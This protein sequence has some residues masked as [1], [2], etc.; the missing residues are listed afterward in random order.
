MRRETQPETTR[1]IMTST[2]ETDLPPTPHSLCL[3][4]QLQLD[5]LRAREAR[6]RQQHRHRPAQ[7]RPRL[8]DLQHRPGHALANVP[9]QK[10]H[11]GAEL[12]RLGEGTGRPHEVR[13]LR[14]WT[15]K[16]GLGFCR[17]TKRMPDWV[18]QSA[19]DWMG[20]SATDQVTQL[21]LSGWFLSPQ[22]KSVP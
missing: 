17:K 16:W 13:A 1:V 21:E 18:G 20:R 5:V 10:G 19:A 22:F 15:P 9:G 11:T 12:D 6:R 8:V 3:Q 7:I 14:G 4:Q 2:T